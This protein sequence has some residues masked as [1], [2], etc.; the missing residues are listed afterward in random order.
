MTPLWAWPPAKW[1]SA[2]AAST[3]T[4]MSKLALTH[5]GNV[6]AGRVTYEAVARDLGYAYAPAEG[7][8]N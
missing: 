6:A 1:S 3:T 7:L 2:S 4:A 8:L 5:C